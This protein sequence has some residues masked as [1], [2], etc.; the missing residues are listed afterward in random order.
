MLSSAVQAEQSRD[1][2]QECRRIRQADGVCKFASDDAVRGSPEK[3]DANVRRLLSSECAEV[4]GQVELEG[5]S[6]NQQVV[7]L[8]LQPVRSEVCK[9]TDHMQAEA[10]DQRLSCHQQSRIL[11]YRKNSEARVSHLHRPMSG[12]STNLENL[13]AGLRQTK[14]R[15]GGAGRL[16]G[17]LRNELIRDVPQK[18]NDR[19]LVTG[20]YSESIPSGIGFMPEE[21]PRCTL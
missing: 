5:M 2:C 21:Q 12:T 20:Y 11:A 3:D 19:R 7:L 1:F 9:R 6:K 4:P 15:E 17:E 8:A 14:I 13:D 18:G 10:P 16:A